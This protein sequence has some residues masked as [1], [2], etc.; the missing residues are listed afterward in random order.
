MHKIQYKKRFFAIIMWGGLMF[1]AI[2]SHGQQYYGE[3]DDIDA[4]LE[5]SHDFS[6]AYMAGNYDALVEIYSEDAR[7]LPPGAPIIRGREDIRKRWILPPDVKILDHHADPEEI[8]VSG[9]YAYDLGTYAGTTR[10]ADGSEVSW[11]GKY[12]IVWI[13]KEGTWYMYADAWNRIDDE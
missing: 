4:I 3:Q 10:R 5:R 6:A 7:I 11:K 12:I 9:N 13:K 8:R 1:S 2:I